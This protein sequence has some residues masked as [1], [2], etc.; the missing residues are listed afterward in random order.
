MIPL[1]VILCI[2]VFIILSMMASAREAAQPERYCQPPIETRPPQLSLMMRNQIAIQRAE[3]ILN[4][5]FCFRCQGEC[6]C[7]MWSKIFL[8]GFGR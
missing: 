6:K 1:F 8:P 5:T 4:N 3:M 2:G 7:G